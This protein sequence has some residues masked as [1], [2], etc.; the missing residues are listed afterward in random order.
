MTTIAILSEGRTDQE[1][2]EQ[3]LLGFFERADDLEIHKIFPPEIPLPGEPEAGGWTVLRRRLAD[4]DHRQALRFNDYVVIHIDTDVCEDAG[5]DVPRR[6]PATGDALDP[7][8]LR[9]AVIERLIEWLGEGFYAA[10]GHRVLFAIAVESIE[11]WLLPLLEDKPAKQRKIAGCRVAA[12][13][14]LQRAGRR[15]L[16]ADDRVRVYANEAAPYRKR[17]TLLKKGPLSPSLGAFL[18]ELTGRGIEI[19]AG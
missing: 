6:A 11:C 19:H 3:V 16:G 14:A 2:I 8:A 18:D 13:A 5:F 17:K 12:D 1:V 10:H 15:L 7:N 4:G 9:T